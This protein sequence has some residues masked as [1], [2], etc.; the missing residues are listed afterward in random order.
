VNAEEM[1]VRLPT[2]ALLRRKAEHLVLL[3][4]FG[5]QGGEAGDAHSRMNSE[6]FMRSSASALLQGYQ[7]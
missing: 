4:P 2:P 7:R 6:R 5:R 1:R 3:R